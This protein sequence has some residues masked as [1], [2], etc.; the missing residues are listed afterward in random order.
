M[1]EWA[2]RCSAKNA[3]RDRYCEG[4]GA[5]NPKAGRVINTVPAVPENQRFVTAP[6]YREPT[7][8]EDAEIRAELA[9]LK[10]A[11][12]WRDT[13]GTALAPPVDPEIRAKVDPATVPIGEVLGK[14]TGWWR[15]KPATESE[16]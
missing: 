15:A 12:W 4:C 9:R 8:E 6:T 13:S 10:A 7:P 1:P 11:P 5:E 2:C 3:D 14:H 16:P